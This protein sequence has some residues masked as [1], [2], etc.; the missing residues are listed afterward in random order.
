MPSLQA[1]AA[2]A[3][4]DERSSWR[5]RGD[6]VGVVHRG[7]SGDSKLRTRL[8]GHSEQAAAVSTKAVWWDLRFASLLTDTLV[9]FR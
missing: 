3:P 8:G 9:T 5:A 4:P 7:S 2:A 1:V 6:S